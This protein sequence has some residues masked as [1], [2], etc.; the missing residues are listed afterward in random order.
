VQ[1]V[2]VTSH[3]PDPLVEDGKALD[4]SLPKVPAQAVAS[5]PARSVDLGLVVFDGDVGL[6][7]GNEKAVVNGDH[8]VND[9]G[10][11]NG[12]LFDSTVSDDGTK[13]PNAPA[14]TLG[15]DATVVTVPAA[16]PAAG[17]DLTVH[18][19]TG[20]DRIRVGAVAVAVDV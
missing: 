19:Q 13:A 12:N 9:P 1:A 8:A 10:R 2:F 17:G 16:V 14:N 6:S 20:E 7:S 15:L 18:V 11:P 4:L 5:G 3:G